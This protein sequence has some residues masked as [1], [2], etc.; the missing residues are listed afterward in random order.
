[1]VGLTS[2]NDFSRSTW[3]VG[4]VGEVPLMSL[5]R[6]LASGTESAS[7]WRWSVKEQWATDI[8]PGG[9]A[10]IQ[11]ILGWPDSSQAQFVD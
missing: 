3:V 5:Y 10:V 6:K 4:S 7:Y 2:G 11:L 1:M 9:R 8:E